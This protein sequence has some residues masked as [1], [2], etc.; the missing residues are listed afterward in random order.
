MN[1][2]IKCS[3]YCSKCEIIDQFNQNILPKS[4]LFELEKNMQV[5]RRGTGIPHL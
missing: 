1:I 2:C 5:F 4:R 3:N